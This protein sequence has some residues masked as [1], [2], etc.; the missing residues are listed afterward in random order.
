MTLTVTLD[1]FNRWWYF[2]RLLY[3]VKLRKKILKMVEDNE[4]LI[5]GCHDLEVEWNG[6]SA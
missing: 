1:Q 4:H 3:P 6:Q 2:L 5:D